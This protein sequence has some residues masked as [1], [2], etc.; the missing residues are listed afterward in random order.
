MTRR[1]TKGNCAYTRDC[2]KAPVEFDQ[3]LTACFIAVIQGLQRDSPSTLDLRKLQM[4][5]QKVRTNA[6]SYGDYSGL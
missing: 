2:E 3:G 4:P 1:S 6:L 5:P